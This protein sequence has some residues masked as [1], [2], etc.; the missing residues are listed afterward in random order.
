MDFTPRVKDDNP[1]PRIACALLLDTSYS[2]NGE[3]IDQLNQGFKLFCE[4]IRKDELAAKR[5]EIAVITFG[6]MARVEIPFTEGR[7]LQPRTLQPNGNTPLGGALDLGL[8]QIESRKAEYKQSGLEYYRPW[9][10]VLTDGAPTDGPAFAAAVGRVRAAETARGLS[11]FGIGVGPHAQMD[12]LTQLS[13]QRAPVRLQGLSFNEFFSWLSASLSSAS[14]SN[15]FGTSD[16]SV[17]Q[18]ESAQQI[19]LPSPAG[20]ATA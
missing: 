4:E 1:D 17:A 5:A 19:P 7:D 12:A 11:V 13:G 8:S 3:P 15:A 18:A 6:G 14:Q 9:M 16:N 10:F 20:W 2:M